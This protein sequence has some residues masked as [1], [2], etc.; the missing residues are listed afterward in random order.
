MRL[1]KALKRW[2]KLNSEERKAWLRAAVTLC[3]IG[4]FLKILP[5][6]TFRKWYSKVSRWLGGKPLT[7]DEIPIITWAVQSAAAI[8][9]FRLQCLPQSLAVKLLLG[10]T[11]DVVLYLGVNKDTVKGF[12]FHAWVEKGGNT[13]IGDLPTKF[14]PLGAWE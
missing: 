10:R 1:R 8:L 11:E 4:L 12:E 3:A 5:F 9:P 6:A 13:I 2:S 14:Q 7:D